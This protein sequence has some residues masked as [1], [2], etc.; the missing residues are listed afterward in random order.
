VY[1]AAYNRWECTVNAGDHAYESGTFLTDT[2]ATGSDGQEYN[3]GR[4]SVA[5]NIPMGYITIPT[6]ASATNGDIY[7]QIS[8]E[9]NDLNFNGIVRD[10]VRY[11]SQTIGF[12][13]TTYAISR[14]GV[15]QGYVAWQL[16]EQS[17]NSVTG[18]A[19]YTKSLN[20]AR[21]RRMENKWEVS[22][23]VADTADNLHYMSVLDIAYSMYPQQ[24]DWTYLVQQWDY[25]APRKSGTF[26]VPKQALQ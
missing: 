11:N 17:F 13:K 22:R 20:I 7:S 24:I 6:A 18:G 16:V 26:T 9:I 10:S 15:G 12:A 25:N 3:L 21:Y 19:G 1:N 23:I 14:I 4:I 2:Y 8:F 5:V